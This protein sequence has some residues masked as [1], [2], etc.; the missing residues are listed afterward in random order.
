M[1]PRDPTQPVE[2]EGV[3]GEEDIS[4]ADA[5]HR[6]HLTPEEQPNATDPD[7]DQPAQEER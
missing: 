1:T 3:P 7:P 6:V 4:E 5:A 2:L